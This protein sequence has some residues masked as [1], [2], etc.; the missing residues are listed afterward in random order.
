MRMPKV[1]TVI[2]ASGGIGGWVVKHALGRG[3][4]VKALVRSS[5][6]FQARMED[7]E[8]CKKTL[9]SVD[10]V[11]GQP[12]DKQTLEQAIDGTDHV[13]SCLGNVNKEVKAGAGV[14]VERATR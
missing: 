10:L 8:V 7:L 11:V 2:G 3:H 6:K 1:V 13:I 14:I 4:A 9:G 5:D 12:L